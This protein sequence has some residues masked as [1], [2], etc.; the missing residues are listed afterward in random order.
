MIRREIDERWDC[1]QPKPGGA[2]Y[3]VCC[4]WREKKLD[5][6]SFICASSR[7]TWLLWLLAMLFLIVIRFYCETTDDSRAWPG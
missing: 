5:V 2:L 3:A 7:L 4:G 6:G 1:Q